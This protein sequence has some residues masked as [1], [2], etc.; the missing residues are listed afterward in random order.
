MLQELFY[1]SLGASTLIKQRVK[2]EL[3]V[4]EEKGKLKKEDI[5]GFLKSLEKKGKKEDKRIKV[6]IKNVLKEVVSEL[7]LATKDDIRKLKKEIRRKL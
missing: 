5:E 2:D 6:E 1:T 7:D 3:S 4:L